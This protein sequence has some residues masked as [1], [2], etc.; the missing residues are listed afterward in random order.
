MQTRL[1][2]AAPFRDTVALLQ[3]NQAQLRQRVRARDRHRLLRQ[4]RACLTHSVQRA[5]RAR[6]M[7]RLKPGLSHSKGFWGVDPAN[8]DATFL[9][10]SRADRERRAQ[11]FTPASASIAHVSSPIRAAASRSTPDLTRPKVP[12]NPQPLTPKKDSAAPPFGTSAAHAPQDAPAR[13]EVDTD[14]TQ[15]TASGTRAHAGQWTELLASSLA[16]AS[17]YAAH[18]H[19][20]YL[21]VFVWDFSYISVVFPAS[22]LLYALVTVP[23]PLYW[24]ALLVYSE[25]LL[26]LQYLWQIVVKL[27]CLELDEHTHRRMLQIGL[28][29]SVVRAD[30]WLAES[31]L[32]RFTFRIP[33]SP[34]VDF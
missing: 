2:E 15:R 31:V 13:T 20:L 4:M 16:A 17:R 5:A 12:D 24:R 25:A 23:P 34:N 22:T 6:R 1:L 27:D 30:P 10:P 7:A 11:L 8:L 21:A 29:D 28:H 3:A 32:L 33:G 9:A 14:S 26:V 19:V 18:V